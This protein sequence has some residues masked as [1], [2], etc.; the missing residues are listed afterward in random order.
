MRRSH[1]T[2]AQSTASHCRLTSPMGVTVHGC[3]VGSPLT[4]CQVTSRPR[5]RFSRYSKWLDTF[6]TAIV[7]N[8]LTSTRPTLLVAQNIQNKQ[9]LIHIAHLKVRFT[10]QSE[11]ETVYEI[12]Y[13]KYKIPVNHINP[14]RTPIGYIHRHHCRWHL[15]PPKRIERKD[16]FDI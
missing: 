6:R 5:D 11:A 8:T 1:S 14:D 3:A 12:Q 9:N 13:K 10:T 16:S 7:Q 4:G 2:Q 15:P